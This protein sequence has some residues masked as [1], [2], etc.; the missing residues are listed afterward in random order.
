MIA[1]LIKTILTLCL[2]FGAGFVI[3]LALAAYLAI[4]GKRQW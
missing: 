4:S 3:L 2:I 1:A